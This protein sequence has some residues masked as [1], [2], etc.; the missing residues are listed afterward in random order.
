MSGRCKTFPAVV[1]FLCFCVIAA[2]GYLLFTPRGAGFVIKK[3]SAV[4]LSS[5]KIGIEE[6]RGR[7]C[8]KL[9][10]GGV[11]I[12]GLKWLPRG[13]SISIDKIEIDSFPLFNGIKYP[14][15]SV[16]NGRLSLPA[17][18]QV[19]FY[20]KFNDPYMDFKVYSNLISISEALKYLREKGISLDISGMLGK[21]DLKITGTFSKPEISGSFFIERAVKGRFTAADCP[22]SFG[23]VLNPGSGPG[24][25]GTIYLKGGRVF[26]PKTAVVN[27]SS[28]RII[29]RGEDMS[30]YL[31]LTARAKVKDVEINIAVKGVLGNLDLT[32]RSTPAFSQEALLL[33]LATNKK[34]H[35]TEKA[36]DKGRLSPDLVND[37]FDYFVLSGSGKKFFK[38]LGIEDISFIY[39]EDTRG[40]KVTTGTFGGVSAS[41]SLEQP[42]NNVSEAPPARKI[43]A[44][45]K[46]DEHVTLGA[47][48]ELEDKSGGAEPGREKKSGE[49]VILK[50]RKDF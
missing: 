31:D 1:L 9:I 26:G 28:G 13:N 7:I 29:Y 43:G 39:E 49:K 45:Y 3:L 21:V 6:I 38:V 19:L 37:F 10:L 33:M 18:E 8:G 32:V 11:K 30:P 35:S 40:I 20:G 50:F 22:V 4:Y 15:V 46:I 2:A 12:E 34:W 17:S 14:S 25:T 47:E 41:Y 16:H 36:A 23:M 5:S 24:V 42:G 27:L 48:K 44:E